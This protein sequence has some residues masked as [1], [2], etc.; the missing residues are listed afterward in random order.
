MAGTLHRPRVAKTEFP[1]YKEPPHVLKESLIH[2]TQS[3]TTKECDII[4]IRKGEISLNLAE[5]IRSGIQ[6]PHF[7]GHRIVPSLL[8]WDEQG[9]KLF[10]KVTYNP[11]YYLTDAEIDILRTYSAAVAN[12]VKP[13]S[14]VLELGSG[15]L[16]KTNIL[17]QALEAQRKDI[18]YYAL[19]L[20]KNELSRSLRQLMLGNF[21]HVRCHGLLGTYDEGRDWLSQAEKSRRPT[22]VLSL[23]S[24][25]GGFTPS[26][27]TDFLHEWSRT[28]QQRGDEINSQLI[29]GLDGNKNGA[30]VF[31]A[32]PKGNGGE[33]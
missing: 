30:E 16:R 25:I 31:D 21:K 7:K 17:L 10:E 13:G 27:A 4:D 18:D 20:D 5:S 29:I 2:N 15:S 22:F 11:R 12:L 23:G 1:R 26:E 19:D 32:S 3:A 33:H 8:L 28:L 24:T 14:I 9:L 6:K